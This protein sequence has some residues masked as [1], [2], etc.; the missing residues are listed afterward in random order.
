[1][2]VH[3]NVVLAGAADQFR[4]DTSAVQAAYMGAGSP[5]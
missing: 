1:V 4:K 3:G 5:S 2:I